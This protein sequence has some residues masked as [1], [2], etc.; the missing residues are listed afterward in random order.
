MNFKTRL[1][2]PGEKTYSRDS[3]KFNDSIIKTISASYSFKMTDNESNN[4]TRNNRNSLK[5]PSSRRPSETSSQFV[6]FAERTSQIYS[7]S[8]SDCQSTASLASS[9]I[10]SN[11]V[12]F[13]IWDNLTDFKMILYLFRPNL[14]FEQS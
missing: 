1:S 7:M 12:L 5:A 8:S 4:I 11:L 14:I 3:M 2:V 10:N 6:R 9:N 13:F